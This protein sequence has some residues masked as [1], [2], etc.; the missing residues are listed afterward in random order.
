MPLQQIILLCIV[1]ILAGIIAG[2][3]GVG[4]GILIVPALVLLFGFSQHAAQG[5]SLAVLLPPVSIFA[6]INYHKNG[7]IDYKV[8][9]ILVLTFFVG[10]YLGSIIA[11]HLPSKTLIRIFGILMLIAGLKMIF[12]K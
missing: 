6:V 11:I 8:A 5:T 10:S 4:G 12:G 9:L 2:S 3:L 7:Y 1:G